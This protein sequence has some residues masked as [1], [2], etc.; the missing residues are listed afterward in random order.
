MIKGEVQGVNIEEIL[1]SK[2]GWFKT[3][4]RG[5]KP[6]DV[7]CFFQ[8]VTRYCHELIGEKKQLE[9]KLANC[10]EQESYIHAAL[11]KAEKAAALTVTE[12]EEERKKI[13]AA[14]AREAR[15]I[16]LEAK[17]SAL[18]MLEET[19]QYKQQVEELL[20]QHKQDGEMLLNKLYEYINNHIDSLKDEFFQEITDSLARLEQVFTAAGKPYTEGDLIGS[21]LPAQYEEKRG[22]HQGEEGEPR[23]EEEEPEQSASPEKD[24]VA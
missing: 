15:E 7:D 18:G 17:Q 16:V 10:R 9:E 22:T 2:E 21:G 24:K 4:F 20:H 23:Q 1:K 6:A 11:I 14:A 3:T 8:E 5:Y 13:L 19:K 12:A